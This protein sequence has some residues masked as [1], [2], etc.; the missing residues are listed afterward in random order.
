MS[1]AP[2]GASRSAAGKKKAK[3]RSEPRPVTQAQPSNAAV[4]PVQ[5]QERS[6][7][8]AGSRA[9]EFRPRVRE[10]G[11]NGSSTGRTAA[12]PA[13]GRASGG[14]KVP[15]QTVDYGYVFK[16]LRVIGALSLFLFGGLAALSILF[17]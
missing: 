1:K 16:D 3:K 6:G 11:A 7:E 5:P 2:H 15:Q 8:E 14:A 12:S 17:R 9:L 4:N 13:S 10:A